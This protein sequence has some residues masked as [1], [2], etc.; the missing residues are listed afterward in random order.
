MK[1]RTLALLLLFP[2]LTY[3]LA[4]FLHP[5]LNPNA[6]ATG[7]VQYDQPSYM[8]S[9]MEY[10]KSQ[11][12]DFT[13]A[14][15]Y[16]EQVEKAKVYFFPQF[17]IVGNLVR[18]TG[19]PHLLVYLTFWFVF[20]YLTF[21]KLFQIIDLLAEKF[22]IKTRF[23]LKLFAA[24]GGGISFILGSLY[25]LFQG[26]I[27]L[28]TF[29]R[30]A[31]IFDPGEGFWMLNV[32]RN[33]IYPME[34]FYHYLFFTVVQK[35]IQ[36]KYWIATWLSGFLLACHP[37]TGI[38]I[39]AS[40]SLFYLLQITIKK[41]RSFLKFLIFT[42]SFFL[43]EV[44]Y[45][46]IY[47]PKNTDHK[48]LMNQWQI[49]W[50]APP[51]MFIIGYSLVLIPVIVTIYKKQFHITTLNLFLIAWLFT[52]I[53]LENHQYFI[54]P[55]HQ[56]LHFSHGYVWLCLFLMGLPTTQ[57]FLS[58][59]SH[60]SLIILSIIVFSDNIAWFTKFTIQ[61]FRG[62]EMFLTKDEERVLDF[63]ANQNKNDII[64][65]QN[66]NVGYFSLLY[67]QNRSLRSHMHNTPK[68]ESKFN[69]IDSVAKGNLHLIQT[70]PENAVW[71]FENSSPICDSLKNQNLLLKTNTLSIYRSTTQ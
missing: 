18:L 71:V 43:I 7:Y 15:P 26:N 29:V 57:E 52:N 31:F 2:I 14:L 35:I 10:V 23:L 8:M 65:S 60:K 13:F 68:S 42:S 61:Q 40:V 3:Y 64:I 48:I 36:Q 50:S 59:I 6:V 38:I 62:L 67:T 30:E 47:L 69:F 41:D 34:A 28:V 39:I 32:G 9:C 58:K 19:L 54:H 22:N 49:N 66:K 53:A 27:N 55:A 37:F 46:F 11:T 25:L 5:I 17:F 12:F 33:L 56:P 4:H 20:S 21:Y 70:Y 51:Y 16:S 44:F 1:N 45:H 63:L 24:W